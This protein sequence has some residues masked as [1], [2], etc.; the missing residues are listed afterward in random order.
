MGWDTHVIV[1]GENIETKKK[2]KLIVD[3]YFENEWSYFQPTSCYIIEENHY[4]RFLHYERRKIT[5]VE[6][7]LNVSEKNPNSKFT[8]LASCPDFIAGPS[9]IIRIEKGIVIDSYGNLNRE[10]NRHNILFE[11]IKNKNIIFEWFKTNGPEEELRNLFEKEYPKN[12][13]EDD[14]A[15]KLI[16]IE[17]GDRFEELINRNEISKVIR[18][19]EKYNEKGKFKGERN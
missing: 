15:S 16:P 11:P 5:P 7:L 17:E 1:I 9:G 10:S 2:A 3:L 13:V 4:S 6:I 14:F 19:W 8:M 12:W 18:G